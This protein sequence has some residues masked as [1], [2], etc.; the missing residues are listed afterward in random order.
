[1]NDKN[2][3]SVG[4][5]RIYTDEKLSELAESLREWV[6]VLAQKQKFGMLGDWCFREGFNPKYFKH[7]S[8][9]HEEFKEAY[10]WAKSW[11][12]HIV[13]RGALTQTLNARFAQFFL[14]CCHEWRTK[15]SE[16]NTTL[17]NEFGKYLELA[18]KDD[19]D[20]DESSDD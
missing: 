10:E 4:R 6:L 5:P 2:K 15:D 14:G 9:Q 8:E 19:D 7:Y 16:D 12:E 3:K 17:A 13:A 1:M 18:K 20:D 11:Q